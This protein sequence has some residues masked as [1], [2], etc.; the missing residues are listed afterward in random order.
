MHWLI[1]VILFSYCWFPF[2]P[3]WLNTRIAWWIHS[4]EVQGVVV[5]I[6]SFYNVL[7]NILECWFGGYEFLQVLFVMVVSYFS[8]NFERYFV[9]YFNLGCW[10]FS[11]RAWNTSLRAFLDLIMFRYLLWFWW[12][13]LY[14]WF[15]SFL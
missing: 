10:L 12:T 2:V 3:L 14:R 15:V 4:V 8:I 11:F 9:G 6:V 13:F 5:H 7:Q 1:F